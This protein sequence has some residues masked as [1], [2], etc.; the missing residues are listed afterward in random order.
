VTFLSQ[1]VLVRDETT[2]QH[3]CGYVLTDAGRKAVWSDEVCECHIEVVGRALEC[4]R[5]GTM[6]GLLTQ[7]VQRRIPYGGKLD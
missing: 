4:R 5:C 3:G 7:V 1:E 2:V 6:Y